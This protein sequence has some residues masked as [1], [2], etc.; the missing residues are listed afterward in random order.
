MFRKL[1]TI[2]RGVALALIFSAVAAAYPPGPAA[3]GNDEAQSY[4]KGYEFIQDQSWAKAIVAFQEHIKKY[5]KS[6]YIDD[7]QFWICFAKE[8][9][10][11]LEES[12]NCYKSFTSSY[13]KSEWANDAKS[14]MIKIGVQ[15][16]KSGVLIDMKQFDKEEDDDVR[17]MAMRALLENGN[18]SPEDALLYYKSEKN[19]EARS[20]IVY[21]L[22]DMESPE[23]TIK[24]GE[25]AISD[26]DQNVKKSAVN[27]LGDRGKEGV[28]ALKKVLTSNSDIEV[29]KAS[30]YALANTGDPA[31]VGILAQVAKTDAN[32]ELAKAS[33]YALADQGS[34]EAIE[35]MQGV[36]AG[37]KSTEVRKSVVYALAD[38]NAITLPM[39]LNLALNDTDPELRKNAV[40][41][42]TELE[43]GDRFEALKQVFYKSKEEEVRKAALYAIMDH[44]DPKAQS[45]LVDVA[46]NDPNEEVAKAAVYSL[47][48]HLKSSDVSILLDLVQKAKS[49]EVRKA[50]IYKA[51]DMGGKES[52]SILAQFLKQ[53]PDPELKVTAI[54]ALG[55]SGSDEAIPVLLNLAKTDPDKQI[56][57]AAVQS[58]GEIGTP[59]AKEA[60]RQLISGQ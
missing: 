10:G 55:E 25:I 4:G 7:S 50:A 45:F 30:L 6:S 52:V 36:L 37:V 48:D 59:K 3:A 20:K 57:M 60:L 23:I 42:I 26:P 14:N 54:R 51:I 43:G 33:V 15:L 34:K 5:P 2:L 39:L 21:M 32:E 18:A 28:P 24:L 47:A 44:M 27:A 1:I 41:A 40:Y 19:P 16:K 17:M 31:I 12:Y 56:R 38:H 22:A 46:I 35:A 58:L 13:P 9:Q 11:Q 29:R 53:N 49:Q 8:K